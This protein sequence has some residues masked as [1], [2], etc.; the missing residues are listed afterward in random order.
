MQSD[1][2]TMLAI[3]YTPHHFESILTETLILKN[4]V[5][6]VTKLSSFLKSV[7]AKINIEPSL[8]RK[9]RLAVEE[10]VVNVI[11]YAYPADTEGSIEVRMMWDGKKL[12][13]MIIDSGVPFDPTVMEK[14][15][16]T[17]SAEE[18]QIGGL[19]IFMV[20]KS[21]DDVKYEYLDGHNILTLKKGLVSK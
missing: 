19:G 6:E 15:D 1:D 10:A 8:A 7:V 3:R 13:V 21:M 11:D 14:T 18:R 20:K 16:T 17:L 4:N 2:L 12:K 9:L 5:H